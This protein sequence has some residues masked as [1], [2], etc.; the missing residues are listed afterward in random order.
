MN[1]T[2][3]IAETIKEFILKANEFTFV[4][5][6][7]KEEDSDMYIIEFKFIKEAIIYSIGIPYESADLFYKGNEQIIGIKVNNAVLSLKKCG[8]KNR[9]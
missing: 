7:I 5:C 6:R 2:E 1:K 4:Y 3:I 9:R 8:E